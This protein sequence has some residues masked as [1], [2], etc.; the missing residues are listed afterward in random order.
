MEK[1]A[2]QWKIN[3]S[4]TTACLLI[5]VVE[6]SW[7]QRYYR[8]SRIL[9]NLRTDFHIYQVRLDL[10]RFISPPTNIMLVILGFKQQLKMVIPKYEETA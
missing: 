8:I 9:N 7:S 4:L 1:V 2:G 6:K 5:K 10:I 3:L